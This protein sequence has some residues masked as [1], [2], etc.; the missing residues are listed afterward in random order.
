MDK[1]N[2]AKAGAKV[3]G[4]SG[5]MLR[6][7]AAAGPMGR[8]GS[9]P[10][11]AP[12]LSPELGTEPWPGACGAGS[13]G[14]WQ[15]AGVEQ[16]WGWGGAGWHSLPTPMEAH[17]A[18]PCPMDGPPHPAGGQA[19]HFGDL[20][21]R[22]CVC[23]GCK[24]QLHNR[25]LGQTSDYLTEAL[26][27]CCIVGL[28]HPL[29]KSQSEDLTV[30]PLAVKWILRGCLCCNWRCNCSTGRQTCHTVWSGS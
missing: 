10:G 16:S 30:T 5:I 28:S 19:G 20:C 15:G 27:S 18:L 8:C 21:F 2:G 22:L 9:T 11:L 4:G 26:F 7:W 29:P 23:A 12:S 3:G 1:G 14:M 17:Q 24:Y 6:L 13:W 25:H